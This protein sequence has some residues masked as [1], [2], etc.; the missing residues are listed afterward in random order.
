MYV[1]PTGELGLVI[2]GLAAVDI[3]LL[4]TLTSDNDQ[5]PFYEKDATE[6]YNSNIINV[7][8]ENEGTPQDDKINVKLYG[9]RFMQIVS[10]SDDPI[11]SA[12]SLDIRSNGNMLKRQKILYTII[13]WVRRLV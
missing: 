4:F 8:M 7:Y 5:R 9:F 3:F 2:I 10:G 13:S 11:E 12:Q 6:K 1:D